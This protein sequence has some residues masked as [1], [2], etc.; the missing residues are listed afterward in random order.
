MSELCYRS[1]QKAGKDYSC[2]FCLDLIKK[3]EYYYKARGNPNGIFQ[4]DRHHLSCTPEAINGK[5]E[6]HY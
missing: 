3:G 6:R 2:G 4:T 1:T 5:E